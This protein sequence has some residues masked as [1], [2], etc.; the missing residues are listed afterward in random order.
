MKKERETPRRQSKARKPVP[1]SAQTLLYGHGRIRRRGD[2]FIANLCGSQTRRTFRS[3]DQ[4]KAWLDAQGAGDG[5]PALTAAQVAEAARAYAILPPGV[6][7]YALA[8]AAA[9]RAAEAAAPI[10]LIPLC[11]DY[12]EDCRARLRPP[13]VAQYRRHLNLALT[14]PLL[15]ADLR[16]HTKPAI[17][18]YLE[19]IHSQYERRRALSTLSALY[20]HL[21]ERD[22]LTANPC[23]TIR[24]PRLPKR[25]PAVLTLDQ[26]RTLIDRAKTFENGAL[27]P[28]IAVCLFAGI[29][30][31]EAMRLRPR[32]I[33]REYITLTASQTKTIHARTVPIQPNLRAILDRSLSPTARLIIPCSPSRFRHH[34][35]ALIVT[36]PF[37]WSQDILRHSYASYRYELTRDAAATASEMGHTGTEIFFQHYRGLVSPGSGLA[38]FS[39]V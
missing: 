31:T 21:V 8:E 38:F 16:N 2:G 18:A 28:Y 27:L 26:T 5:L 33:G 7:L 22:L 39:V 36:L 11:I 29:R 13:T 23:A 14:S 6:S 25:P 32:D 34:L 35:C 12:I 10:D 1:K 20:S 24:Q 19:S 30:P 37:A 9:A 3:L 15:G 17:R 4:A